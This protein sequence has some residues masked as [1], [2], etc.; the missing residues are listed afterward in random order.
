MKQSGHAS[1]WVHNDRFATLC[2][3]CVH[4][5]N[6]M[7]NIC[8]CSQIILIIPNKGKMKWLLMLAELNLDW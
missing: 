1:G 6:F 8:V 5:H 2:H 7:C 4:C 3:L